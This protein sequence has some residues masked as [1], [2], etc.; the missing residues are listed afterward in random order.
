MTGRVSGVQE[1]KITA[2]APPGGYRL[3]E[4]GREKKYF[5]HFYKNPWHRPEF[6]ALS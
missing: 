3:L 5:V 1:T 6:Q 2:L 4:S